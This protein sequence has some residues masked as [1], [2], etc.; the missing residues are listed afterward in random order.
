[1][2]Q[3]RPRARAS[4]RGLVGV[5][6]L[7]VAVS[8]L[9][10]AVALGLGA[11]GRAVAGADPA[12]RWGCSP[13]RPTIS[14][15]TVRPGTVVEIS[16]GPADCAAGLPADAAFGVTLRSEAD[17]ANTAEHSWTSRVA[18]ARDGS[19]E[20]SFFLPRDFPSGPAALEIDDYAYVPCHDTGAG[21]SDGIRLASCAAHIT[22]L[23]IAP[24]RSAG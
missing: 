5:A 15:A 6:A 21:R 9:V 7:V 23:E 16:A 20:V 22:Q 1:M 4:A 19:F 18:V 11:H 2:E 10:I 17:A 24:L 12:D 8:A 13:A 14:P 3:S